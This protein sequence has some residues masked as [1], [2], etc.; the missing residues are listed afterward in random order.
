MS[1][2]EPGLY[3]A[4][5]ETKVYSGDKNTWGFSV[6]RIDPKGTLYNI[7]DTV[8]WIFAG[9]YY[10]TVN[11]GC[12]NIYMHKIKPAPKVESAKFKLHPVYHVEGGSVGC[13]EQR[14]TFKA[15]YHSELYSV[16]AAMKNTASVKVA[17]A[18]G[19]LDHQMRTLL[20][21]SLS[22]TS[23][24]SEKIEMIKVDMSVPCYI[25]QGRLELT[26]SDGTI[27]TSNG[28]TLVQSPTSLSDAG[29]MMELVA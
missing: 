8:R 6:V 4:T 9:G 2:S 26:M 3:I 24:L 15:G 12:E 14:L 16:Q 20:D 5:S 13:V 28:Q 25:Y 1:W 11:G 19:V 21:S 7:T 29:I 27:E 23:E 22:S 17:S 10:G 18:G